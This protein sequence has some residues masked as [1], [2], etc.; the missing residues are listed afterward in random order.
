MIKEILTASGLQ[1]RR[2]S[3]PKRLPDSTFVYYFD[4]V[5]MDGADRVTPS[6]TTGLPC[7]YHHDVRL[8]V[9]EP[10]ADPAA[11]AALEAQI[12][13]RGLTFTK[14]D[15]EWLSSVQRYLVNYELSY[16]TKT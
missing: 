2:G 13:A 5:E 7:I 15:R 11:E 8:E 9:Y 1:H 4:D 12:R 10:Q 16:T 6:T 14:Y 3:S